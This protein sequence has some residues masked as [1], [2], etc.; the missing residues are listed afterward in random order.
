MDRRGTNTPHQIINA[1]TIDVEE[2]FHSFRP[3][4]LCP[5]ETWGTFQ[6]RVEYPTHALLDLLDKNQYKATFFL[7]GC[8]AEHHKSLAREIA[9]RGHEVGAHGYAHEPIYLQNRDE[10]HADVSKTKAMIEDVI[11]APVF[12]YRAPAFSIVPG[13]AWAWE[14]LASLG[15]Q[16]DSSVYPIRGHDVYGF[17]GASRSP[18][19]VAEGLLEIPMTTVRVLGYNLPIGGGGYFRIFPYKLTQRGLQRVNN[20]GHRAVVYVHPWE[21]DPDQPRIPAPAK[22]RLRHYAGINGNEKKFARLLSDFQFGPI[23]EA[24]KN[25]IDAANNSTDD[26]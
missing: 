26:R 4:G 23:N 10:F 1:L 22:V 20:L 16:Y 7:L 9:S 3:L 8:I 5:P 6:S 11:S 24:F 12:G 21:F 13:T 2:Y 18:W 14:I 15:F 17:P 25:E 19:V